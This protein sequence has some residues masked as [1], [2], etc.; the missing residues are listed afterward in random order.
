L[1]DVTSGYL[2]EATFVVDKVF[3]AD[4][5]FSKAMHKHDADHSKMI[6]NPNLLSIKFSQRFKNTQGKLLTWA[7]VARERELRFSDE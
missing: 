7:V 4:T 1:I 6:G 3:G 2:R 5:A